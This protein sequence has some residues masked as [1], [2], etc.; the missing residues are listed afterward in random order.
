MAKNTINTFISSVNRKANDTVY[1]FVV[2]YPLDNAIKCND[3]EY[4]KMNVVSFDMLNT[5]YNINSTNN[6]FTLS[7]YNNADVFISTTMFN[8][9]SGNYSVITLK[10]VLISLLQPNINV[11]YNT[12]QNT[13]TFTKIIVNTNKY[14]ITP[15][16]T[17]S[18][19][20]LVN[21]TINLIP[22][23]GFT[24]SYINLVNYKKI[25]IRTQNINYFSNNIENV[26]TVGSKLSFSDIIF[27]K[28]K[29][30]IEP[31]RNISY[32]NE[33]AGNSFNLTLQDKKITNMRLQLKNEYGEFITDA[34]DYLLV[35]QF[36]IHEKQELFKKS[37]LSM[38][39]NVRDIWVSI[40]WC[41]E[42]LKLLK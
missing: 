25:I 41:M 10:N 22:S 13:F 20:G 32:S 28:S 7:I 19:L 18:F 23:G 1:D 31:F 26:N 39:E 36:T 29:Q 12:A 8:I 42:K 34:P 15:L 6:Q 35:I 21:G 2:E 9:P 5:M 40:L 17:G 11:A 33:D 27:W 4:I 16:T 14:Y 37:I 38:A 3:N 24:T 30:D